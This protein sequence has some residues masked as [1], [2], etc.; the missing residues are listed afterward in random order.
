MVGCFLEFGCLVGLVGVLVFV[1]M[2]HLLRD[3]TGSLSGHSVFPV[4]CRMRL[5]NKTRTYCM[6]QRVWM[7]Q[8]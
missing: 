3:E 7:G 1:P 2:I 6:V 8:C 4:S 5:Y